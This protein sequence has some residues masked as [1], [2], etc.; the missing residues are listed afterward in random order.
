MAFREA[1]S[2]AHFMCRE[3]RVLRTKLIA[4]GYVVHYEGRSNTVVRGAHLILLLF[5]ILFASATIMLLFLYCFKIWC[6]LFVQTSAGTF[7]FFSVEFLNSI[8]SSHQG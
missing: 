3:T 1:T 2:Y 6:L 7:R 4:P 8:F 5:F